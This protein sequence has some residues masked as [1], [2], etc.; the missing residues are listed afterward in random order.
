MLAVTTTHFQPFSALDAASKICHLFM[1][2][3]DRSGRPA[4]RS[5]G[6]Q[7][8]IADVPARQLEYPLPSKP[9]VRE[10]IPFTF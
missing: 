1:W 3:D 10:R 4:K 6:L 2:A 9:D 5:N 7:W 8:D